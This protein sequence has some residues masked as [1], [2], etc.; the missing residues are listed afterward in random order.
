M[1]KRVIWSRYLGNIYAN[2]ELS[3]EDQFP[4]FYLLCNN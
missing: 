1:I 2:L 3:N 4:T